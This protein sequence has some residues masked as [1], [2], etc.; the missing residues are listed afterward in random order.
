MKDVYAVESL[1]DRLGIK[2]WDE[3]RWIVRTLGKT[4]EQRAVPSLLEFLKD[5]FLSRKAQSAVNAIWRKVSSGRIRL[6]LCPLHLSRFEKRTINPK[7]ESWPVGSKVCYAACRVCGK[8]WPLK[9]IREVVV[10]L[11][12]KAEEEQVEAGEVLKVN[13]LVHNKRENHREDSLFDFDRVEIGAVRDMEVEQFVIRVQNDMDEFR[14]KRYKNI[15]CTMDSNS[16]LS[17]HTLLML[18][19]VFGSAE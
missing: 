12:G 7:M 17:E 14:R 6:F 19:S 8:P 5:E 9:E 4:G 13:W 18:R 11:D 10:V 16:N 2:D 15:S 1:V 3:Q